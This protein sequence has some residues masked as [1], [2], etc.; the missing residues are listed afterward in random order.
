[1]DNR[2]QTSFL[3]AT[4]TISLLIL[5]W[6]GYS[7]LYISFEGKSNIKNV[8]LSFRGESY[9]ARPDSSG[10][11]VIDLPKDIP[12]AIGSFSYGREGVDI[13][14]VPRKKQRITR[15]GRKYYF[16][17]A[18]E[19]VNEYLHSDLLKTLSLKY[20]KTEDSVIMEWEK[21]LPK[22]MSHLNKSKLPKEFK[23]KEK[24]RLYY[25]TAGLL[26]NY[27][28]HHSR[29][30]N[31]NGFSPTDKF[32]DVLDE[33][34]EENPTGI[35]FWQYRQVFRD[36]IQLLG[37]KDSPP[38]APYQQLKYQLN[39]VEKNIKER[40]LSEYLIDNFIYSYIRYYGVDSLDNIVDYYNTNVSDENLRKDFMQL[41][42]KHSRLGKGKPA[43]DFTFA[44]IDENKVTLSDLKGNYVFIDIWATW[45][46]P[47]LKEMPV[48]EK[49]FKQS[50]G[51]NICFVS[52]SID[53]DKKAW[54]DK[55]IKD[56]MEWIQL[57]AGEDSAFKKNYN[58]GPIPRFVLIDPEGKI[59]DANMTKPSF[60]K[61]I[62]ILGNL[63]G[64]KYSMD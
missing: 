30:K 59:I 27:P 63:I 50:K 29:I 10:I 61:T 45:C 5:F 46:I 48:I 15:K 2:I 38:N 58:L 47:C 54:K 31:L 23:R 18:G 44:D 60:P 4:V 36:W 62:E 51:K 39:Y 32:Y 56:K 19:K 28:L 25:V 26:L 21:V 35:E 37:G 64:I 57:Y 41:F 1:M 53:A 43:P 33:F 9:S 14:I 49:L 42:D 13:Y 12:S 16:S 24:V 3:K 52:I 17:G 55:V 6:P 8:S 20:E 11:F 22:L 7:Q 34:I 40:F